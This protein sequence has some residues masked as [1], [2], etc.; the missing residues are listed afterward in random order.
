MATPRLR[1]PL[2]GRF[3]SA[4]TAATATLTLE[5][6]TEVPS[7]PPVQED[8]GKKKKGDAEAKDKG[9]TKK[10]KKKTKKKAEA[11]RKKHKKK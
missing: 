7:L 5:A 3:I 6:P 10:T 1:D 2:T 4:A 11:K 9:K 8:G